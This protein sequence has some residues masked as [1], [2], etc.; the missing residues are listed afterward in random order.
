MHNM[1]ETNNYCLVIIIVGHYEWFILKLEMKFPVLCLSDFEILTCICYQVQY[2]IK[3][4]KYVFIK[5]Y[6]NSIVYM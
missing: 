5:I 6:T 2:C 3:G 4:V 1:H